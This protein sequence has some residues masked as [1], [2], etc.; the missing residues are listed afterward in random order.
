LAQAG[1]NN[2]IGG[3]LS[4]NT[5]VSTNESGEGG[6][7]NTFSGV[8]PLGAESSGQISE[9]NNTNS[10]NNQNLLALAFLGMGNFLLSWKYWLFLAIIL[11]LFFIIWR[12]RNRRSD[13]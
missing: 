6:I 12:R 2:F 5:S 1:G 8:N 9:E 11:I 10:N 7:S 3:N 4:E 13:I